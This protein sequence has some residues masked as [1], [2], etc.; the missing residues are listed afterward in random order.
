MYLYSLWAFVACSR[1][2]FISEHRK[3][4]I[5]TQ[6]AFCENKNRDYAESKKNSV[7][8]LLA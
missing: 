7:N 8:F 2:N 5:V 6:M 3:T 4:K 1:V